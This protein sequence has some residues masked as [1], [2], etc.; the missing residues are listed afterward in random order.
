MFHTFLKHFTKT[1]F[2]LGFA[3][4]FQLISTHSANAAVVTWDGS[5]GDGLW[6]TGANWSTGSKPGASDTATF[7]GTVSL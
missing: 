2:L 5:S 1:V 3:V 7:D 6:S 4:F